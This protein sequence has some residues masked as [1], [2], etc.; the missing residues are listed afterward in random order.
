MKLPFTTYDV[1]TTRRFGGNPLAIVEEAD[2]LT[3]APSYRIWVRPSFAASAAA[4]LTDAAIG[5]PR[6]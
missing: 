2:Q 3:D 6:D 1:F 4:W 5:L